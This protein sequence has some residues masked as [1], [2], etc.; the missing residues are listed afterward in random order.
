MP[1]R[2]GPVSRSFEIRL[3]TAGNHAVSLS[4]PSATLGA[5]LAATIPGPGAGPVPGRQTSITGSQYDPDAQLL[6]AVHDAGTPPIRP[7]V[8]LHPEFDVPLPSLT[9]TGTV[10]LPVACW[11]DVAPRWSE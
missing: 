5:V 9:A 11:Y 10:K 3:F 7:S 6:L 2:P 1:T 4:E 8:R